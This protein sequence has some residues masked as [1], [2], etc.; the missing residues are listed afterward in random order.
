MGGGGLV[1]NAL[2][3]GASGWCSGQEVI[4]SLNG[5]FDQDPNSAHYQAAKNASL[6]DFQTAANSG[7]WQDLSA[8]YDNAY[9]AAG[10]TPCSG[11]SLYLKAL[12]TLAPLAGSNG[13]NVDTTA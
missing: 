3:V 9:A 10:L 7:R 13:G 11:W 5:L 12:G 6:D 1:G 4:D 2:P 8:A